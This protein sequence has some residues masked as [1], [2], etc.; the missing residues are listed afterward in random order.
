MKSYVLLVSLCLFLAPASSWGLTQAG[1]AIV[2]SLENTLILSQRR[3][4]ELT[5]SAQ[6]SE[7][8]RKK[9]LESSKLLELEWKGALKKIGDLESLSTEQ[10]DII[11][12]QSREYESLMSL[13]SDLLHYCE[14]L[15]RQN[16]RQATAIKVGAGALLLSVLANIIQAVI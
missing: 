11:A 13:H 16:K 12:T 5:I 8:S 1:T 10:Q 9:I 4:D 2:D 6:N 7:E 14:T 15:E 3:I